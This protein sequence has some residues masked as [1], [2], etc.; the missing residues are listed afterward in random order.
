M[1]SKKESSWFITAPEF[2]IP[3]TAQLGACRTPQI[4][5]VVLIR[6][7]LVHLQQKHLVHRKRGTGDSLGGIFLLKQHWLTRCYANELLEAL[8]AVWGMRRKRSSK[9]STSFQ[10]F[11][12]FFLV[13]GL[14]MG[15]SAFG[16]C[17]FPFFPPSLWGSLIFRSTILYFCHRKTK[18]ASTELR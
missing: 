2:F 11:I 8:S 3:N 9:E 5:Q 1:S 10:V 14:L 17:G 4:K 6:S 12:R 16:V 15:I 13:K 18:A 7:S